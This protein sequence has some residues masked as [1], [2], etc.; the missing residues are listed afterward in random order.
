MGDPDNGHLLVPHF[1]RA[2]GDRWDPDG[3]EIE[4]VAQRLTLSEG[5]PDV[6]VRGV[7]N[8]TYPRTM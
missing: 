8:G 6:P 5:A 4:W 1:S 2:L 3:N 7:P